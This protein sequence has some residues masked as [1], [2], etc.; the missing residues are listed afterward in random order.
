[1][2]FIKRSVGGMLVHQLFVVK[3]LP[4]P[5]IE[6]INLVTTSEELEILRWPSD[7]FAQYTS[8]FHVYNILASTSAN[9]FIPYFAGL[10]SKYILN[11]HL[12]LNLTICS[13]IVTHSDGKKH[14]CTFFNK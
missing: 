6:F 11:G 5:K 2:F 8:M 1:M 4:D 3:F 13:S 7:C 9:V 10:I 14:F 12:P